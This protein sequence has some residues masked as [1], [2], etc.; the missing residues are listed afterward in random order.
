[1]Y[2]FC[3]RRSGLYDRSNGRSARPTT[4]FAVDGKLSELRKGT[5]VKENEN[6]SFVVHR[7]FRKAC[8][9]LTQCRTVLIMITIT[10]RIA[11]Y[12]HCARWALADKA[13]YQRRPGETAPE[14][15]PELQQP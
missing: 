6:R 1:M 15:E 13:P 5:A 7:R 9:V 4:E 2:E 3:Y 12:A 10:H 11:G 14:K 8:A